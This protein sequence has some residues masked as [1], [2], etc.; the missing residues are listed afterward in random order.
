MQIHIQN[1]FMHCWEQ[2]IHILD[3]TLHYLEVNQ[4]SR[5]DPKLLWISFIPNSEYFAL[6]YCSTNVTVA[7]VS[8]KCYKRLK[9]GTMWYIR[10]NKGSCYL[11]RVYDNLEYSQRG[12]GIHNSGLNCMC[13][14]IFRKLHTSHFFYFLHISESSIFLDNSVPERFS[15]QKV[16]TM[17][18]Q[19]QSQFWQVISPRHQGN[20]IGKFIIQ[21]SLSQT[22]KLVN[23]WSSKAAR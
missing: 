7:K 13:L 17:S 18:I 1:Y 20:S 12:I 11:L 23:N 19:R 6:F 22:L 16:C 4:A 3:L 10:C 14:K 21:V 15:C 8:C 5:K 9:I 2:C